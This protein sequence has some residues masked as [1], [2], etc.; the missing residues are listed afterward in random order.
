[1]IGLGD[2]PGGDID[3]WAFSVSSNG[4][5][6]VGKSDS[7]AGTEAFRWTEE[8]GMIGLGDLPGGS[9]FSR[10]LDVSADGSV[11][12]GYGMS[13]LGY[14]AFR[15]TEGE[16]MVGLGDLPGEGFCSRARAVSDDGSI[17]VGVANDLQ[18][19]EHRAFIV[20][21]LHGMRDLQKVLEGDYGFD[22]M[23]WNLKSATGISADGL[24][25]VGYG[26][27][28]N[29]DTE[30]WIVTLPEPSTSVLIE[31]PGAEPSFP[32]CKGPRSS[33]GEGKERVE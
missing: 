27:N 22:L 7:E 28:P 4:Q 18:G 24:T 10:A 21:P 2:L 25:I 26:T 13:A 16:G 32:S 11:V 20:D 30:A 19:S 33:R 31:E 3:S 23:G 1:M 5:T 29:G 12:V 9:H 15:W 8:D 17:I 6:V 14:E